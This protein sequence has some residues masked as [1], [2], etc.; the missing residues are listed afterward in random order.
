MNQ[1][2]ESVK[3]LLDRDCLRRHLNHGKGFCEHFTSAGEVGKWVYSCFGC[4]E[5]DVL[6]DEIDQATEVKQ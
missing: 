4:K 2:T 5:N 3:Q 6:A 1:K